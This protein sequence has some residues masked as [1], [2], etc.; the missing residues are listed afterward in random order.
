VVNAVTPSFPMGEKL[1]V[2]VVVVMKKKR[3]LAH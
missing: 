1:M 3:M 2:M